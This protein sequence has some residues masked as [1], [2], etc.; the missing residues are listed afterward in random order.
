MTTLGS[1]RAEVIAALQ[2]AD[3]RA[4]AAPGGEVPYV[5]VAGDG[6]NVTRLLAGLVQTDWRLIL[7]GGA[8]D[9]EAAATELDTL[10]QSVLETLRALDGWAVG[11]L[12]RDGARDWAGGLY[13]TADISASRLVDV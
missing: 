4:V 9:E 11:E 8:W 6:G 7:V 3:V 12:G 13:L 2:A 10:K 1:A 5:Y